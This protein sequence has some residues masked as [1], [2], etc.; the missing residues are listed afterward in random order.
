MRKKAILEVVNE[1]PNDV[2]LDEV[3]ERLIILE[4]IESGLDDVKNGRVIDHSTLKKLS[5]KWSR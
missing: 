5:K 2:K 1:L 4:K 3:I